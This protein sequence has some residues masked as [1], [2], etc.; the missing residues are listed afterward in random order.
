MEEIIHF[1]FQN[2]MWLRI[3]VYEVWLLNNETDAATEEVRMRQT[4]TADSCLARSLFCRMQY[5][6]HL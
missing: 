5:L 3:F 6:S 1:D 4:P 2:L